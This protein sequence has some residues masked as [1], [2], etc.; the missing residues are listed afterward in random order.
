MKKRGRPL[1]TATL[2]RMRFEKMISEFPAHIPRLTL[3]EKTELEEEF[4]NDEA[5]R[6]EILKNYKHGS[7]TP[8]EHAYSMASLGDE[9]FEGHKQ[10]FLDDDSKYKH[11]AKKIR[12]NAG[13]AIIK[14]SHLRQ[15]KV[16]EINKA[17]IEKINT[18]KTYTL[19]RVASLIH[20]QW[21]SMKPAQRLANEAN[22]MNCRGDDNSPASVRSITRWIECRLATFDK[23]R[24]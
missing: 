15:E 24:S 9:S 18:T 12:V 5:I 6:L 2:E 4:R 7:W 13:G 21:K 19:H 11:K 1:G 16:M 3:K 10:K 8:D 17:L 14:K 20:E 22:S 23:P